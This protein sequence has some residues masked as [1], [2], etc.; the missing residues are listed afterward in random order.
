MFHMCEWAMLIRVMDGGSGLGR[1]SKQSQC[2]SGWLRPEESE[3][4]NLGTEPL[5]R[6]KSLSGVVSQWLE[7]EVGLWRD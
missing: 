3:L 7:K 1:G 2:R 4:D 5:T 6:Y